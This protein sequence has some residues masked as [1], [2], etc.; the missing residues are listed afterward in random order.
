MRCAATVCVEQVLA[1]SIVYMWNGWSGIWQRGCSCALSWKLTGVEGTLGGTGGWCL[2][3]DWRCLHC[4]GCFGVPFTR[5]W[6]L[7]A[8]AS[9]SLAC[10]SCCIPKNHPGAPPKTSG[11]H[12]SMHTTLRGC[13]LKICVGFGFGWWRHEF[14][15]GKH[16]SHPK[17]SSVVSGGST[18]SAGET[19][20]TLAG[21]RC[22]PQN[23]S[24]V[25]EPP[26]EPAKGDPI[27]FP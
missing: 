14:W 20:G 15:R 13:D 11:S 2:F 24:A 26:C 27:V 10:T 23:W 18:M 4:N 25:A 7:M 16:E 9:R 12:E 21:R 19:Q 8:P 22:T 1:K 5:C 17:V 3:G 6:C